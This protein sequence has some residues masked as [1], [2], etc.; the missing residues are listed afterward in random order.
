MLGGPSSNAPSRR[1]EMIRA[2]RFTMNTTLYKF[3]AV[4]FLATPAFTYQ[5]EE[6]VAHWTFNEPSGTVLTD[7]SGNPHNAV[8]EPG[9]ALGSSGMM[10]ESGR[11]AQFDGNVGGIAKV[12]DVWPLSGLTFNFSVAAWVK[13]EP[14]GPSSIR[15]ILGSSGS[16]GWSAGVTANGLRFTNKG[17]ADYDLAYNYP[18]STWFH[19]AYVFD[20]FSDVTFYVDGVP[21]GQR[22]GWFTPDH[23]NA[24][25][26]IGAYTES[27]Q[28]WHGAMDDLQVYSGKFSAA[29]VLHLYENPGATAFPNTG[30]SQCFGGASSCPC[31]NLGQTG[32]GCSNST[33]A[34]GKLVAM[35]SPSLAV[36][37]MEF[38][39]SQLPQGGMSV[40]FMGQQSLNNGDGILFG[41]GLRCAGG[42]I[43]RLGIRGI[44][45][46]GNAA[47]GAGL[48]NLGQWGP[49][50]T[51]T[52]QVWYQDNGG[53]PCGVGSNTSQAIVQTFGY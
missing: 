41:D 16:V 46:L 45:S 49:G 22:N 2:Q 7:L 47:W 12:P 29:E 44:D 42:S 39:C 51:R 19:V 14:G 34:G 1:G 32:E 31:G 53:S 38:V 24:P 21:I 35:G 5:V 10:A 40:L 23:P 20:E 17:V 36:D 28:F 13:V 6:L 50:D 33:G 52:F 43:R 11:A 25:W 3:L 26:L 15:R 48:R 8:L 9:V 30:T 4:C 18:L 27:S 37:N